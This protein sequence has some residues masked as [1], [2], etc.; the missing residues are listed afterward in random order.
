MLLYDNLEDT[1]T[2]LYNT[3]V[4]YS[5]EIALI[6]EVKQIREKFAVNLA[7]LS[8]AYGLKGKWVQIDD[9]LLNYTEFDLGYMNIGSGSVW[10][11]RSPQRQYQQGLRNSQCTYIHSRPVEA[12]NLK[13]TFDVPTAMMLE[14]KYPKLA[15]VIGP[16]RSFEYKFRAINSN[17]A[18]SWDHIHSDYILDYKGKSVAHMK[19]VGNKFDITLMDRFQY[20]KEYANEVI[21]AA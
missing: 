19:P 4:M 9:P 7:T 17:L 11:C 10:W 12:Y 5:G 2:K 15:D 18:V 1:K 21:N 6:R 20:L 14:N 16:L 13:V 8:G 3:I